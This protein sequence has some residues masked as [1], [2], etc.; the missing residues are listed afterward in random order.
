M[1]AHCV[2]SNSIRI[3]NYQSI[4]KLTTKEHTY[5]VWTTVFN[6]EN[7]YKD[8]SVWIETID[9]RGKIITKTFLRDENEYDEDCET[10]KV[11]T[12]TTS[13]INDY[14]K[15]LFVVFGRVD[16]HY[17]FYG[18]YKH[19][20]RLIVDNKYAIIYE[21]VSNTFTYNIKI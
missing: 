10:I 14:D 2:H 7:K 5:T 9:R 6:Q 4:P 1:F 19:K 13:P 17:K 18:I 16:M 11:I 8:N 3:S 20:E 12:N 15:R 21:K